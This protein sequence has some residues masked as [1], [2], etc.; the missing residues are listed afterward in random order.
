MCGCERERT[1]TVDK[2]M[3]LM[4]TWETVFQ[5][6]HDYLMRYIYIG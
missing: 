2:Q 6:V 4:L 3:A 1:Q 5:T